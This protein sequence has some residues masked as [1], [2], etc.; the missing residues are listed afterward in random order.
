[1][2]QRIGPERMTTLLSRLLDVAKNRG[3]LSKHEMA[4]VNVDTT[5]Q[6]KAIAFPTD[7]GL[8]FK[9][10][11]RLTAHARRCDITLRQSYKCVSK[12]ALIMQGHYRHA[13]Q[14]KRAN[15]QLRR[16]K[17]YLG[18]VVRDIERK[19]SKP[20][21][22]LKQDLA[23]AHRLLIQKRNSKNKI[24]SLHAPEVECISKGKAH[25]RY[26]FGCKINVVYT[27]KSNW[28][29]GVKAHHGNPFDGHTLAEALDVMEVITGLRAKH[30]HVDKGY[31]G[32]R[33]ESPSA[34]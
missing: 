33:Y 18:R 3:K 28:I 13:K 29:I 14:H 12:K 20:D 22:A 2:A 23:L 4:H 1:M 34:G 30:V 31:R 7:A 10:L 9:M 32:R 15:K 25:K 19:C 5:V 16:L 26:E 17:T 8:Y 6:E 27:S 24:Y 21:E 11:M